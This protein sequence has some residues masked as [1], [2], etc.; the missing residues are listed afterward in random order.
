MAAGQPDNG[1]D[2]FPPQL[3]CSWGEG[4]VRGPAPNRTKTLLFL[5]RDEHLRAPIQDREDSWLTCERKYSRYCTG[6]MPVH[7]LNA[8]VKALV[9]E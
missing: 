6:L 3:F 1:S 9:S 2:I 7:W 5:H 4:N 8:R